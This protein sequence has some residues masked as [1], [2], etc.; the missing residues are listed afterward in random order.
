MAHTVSPT[1]TK[2]HTPIDLISQTTFMLTLNLPICSTQ[3]ESR[4]CW[5]V[6][7]THSVQFHALVEFHPI[8]TKLGQHDLTT[9][10]MLNC[11]GIFHIS[12]GLA[13][14]RLQIYGEEGKQEVCY[15]RLSDET[16]NRGPDS[17]WSLKN[18][19]A[20]L[21]KSR[22]VTPVSWPNSHHWPLSIMAS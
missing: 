18:P 20:L 1:V 7:K 19:K 9:L 6:W 15:K 3:Q 10:R 13:I 11:K 8:T 17:L 22:G 2:I 5:I 12:N 16:L 21:V 14:V 4:P